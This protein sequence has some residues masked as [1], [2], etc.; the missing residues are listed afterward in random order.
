[1]K[2]DFEKFKIRYTHFKN[3]AKEKEMNYIHIGKNVEEHICLPIKDC[4]MKKWKTDIL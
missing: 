2:K 1:L 3:I 4:N